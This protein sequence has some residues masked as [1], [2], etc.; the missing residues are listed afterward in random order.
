MSLVGDAAA[1]MPR[2]SFTALNTGE[3]Y[4]MPYVPN[5]FSEKVSASYSKQTIVGMSHQNY[6]YSH[7]ENHTFDNLNFYFRANTVNELNL[8]HEGRKFLLSLC[9]SSAGASSVSQN[10][11]TK[12]LFIWP[13][14]VTMTCIVESVSITHEKFN[15]NGKTVQFRATIKVTEQRNVRLTSE[16]VRQQG[17]NRSA[18]I[19]GQLKDLPTFLENSLELRDLPEEFQ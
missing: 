8:I 1:R 7:T 3:T 6:Q 9:Y 12:I 19:S 2:V 4:Y 10:R 15:V 13:T 11:P 14:V 16:Q 17:T 18:D 5:T